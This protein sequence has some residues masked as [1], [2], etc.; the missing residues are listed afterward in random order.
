MQVARVAKERGLPEDRV[1]ELVAENTD[2]RDWGVFGE[3]GVNVT[4]L[5]IALDKLQGA[6]QAGT[7]R[8]EGK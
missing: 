7:A 8:A 2:R 5:N 4:M 1:R 6:A 3:D